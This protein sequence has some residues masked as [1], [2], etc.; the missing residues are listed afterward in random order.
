LYIA[1]FAAVWPPVATDPDK[2]NA[3]AASMYP[4][5]LEEIHRDVSFLLEQFGSLAVSV[6]VLSADVCQVKSD[7]ADVKQ[8]AVEIKR[9][10]DA[11]S[12]LENLERLPGIAVDLSRI[13]G[14]LSRLTDLSSEQPK[15]GTPE[16]IGGKSYVS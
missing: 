8:V 11:L 7:Q 9:L 14:V 6:G 10:A 15:T 5:Y 16:D 4:L 2:Q 13:A 12:T 1:V 3:S